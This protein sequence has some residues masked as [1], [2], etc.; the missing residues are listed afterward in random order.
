MVKYE[1]CQLVHSEEYG[2]GMQIIPEQC[3]LVYSSLAP[4]LQSQVINNWARVVDRAKQFSCIV[5]Q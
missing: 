2:S 1:S 4:T 3:R 5:L